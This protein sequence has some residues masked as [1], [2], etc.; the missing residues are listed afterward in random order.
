[1]PEPIRLR[2]AILEWKGGFLSYDDA[3]AIHSRLLV[4]EEADT[5]KALL[6]RIEKARQETDSPSPGIRPAASPTPPP[7]K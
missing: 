2:Y 3:L 7:E 1:M 4:Q 5:L 6:G